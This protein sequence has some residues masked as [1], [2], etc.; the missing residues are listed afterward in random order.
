MK[1]KVCF[2]VHKEHEKIAFWSYVKVFTNFSECI[3]GKIV[4]E[5]TLEERIDGCD[6]IIADD[7]D[8]IELSSSLGRNSASIIIPYAQTLY[9]L[10]TLR[11]GKKGIKRTIGSFLPLHFISKNYVSKMK[12]FTAI[13]AN[14]MGTAS[15]LHHL[16]NL[17]PT[18]VLNPGLNPNIYKPTTKKEDKILIFG[19]SPYLSSTIDPVDMTAVN[20]IIKEAKK[21]DLEVHVFGRKIESDREIINHEFIPDEELIKLYSSSLITFTPQPFELFGLVPVESA[22]CGTPVISTYYHDALV[23]GVNGFVFH[24]QHIS[25]QFDRAMNLERDIIIQS[26]DKFTTSKTCSLLNDY[27]EEISYISGLRT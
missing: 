4:N 9:G 5:E 27:L 11:S 14:S 26:V 13:F 24:P 23:P 12:M 20:F 22:L 7:W 6:F 19:S 16:Y 2:Y 25:V 10:N 21:R 1:Q 18:Y 17:Y 8:A 15:L 3:G